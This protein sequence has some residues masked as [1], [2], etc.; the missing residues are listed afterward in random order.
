M[1]KGKTRGIN[2]STDDPTQFSLFP[3]K[4]ANT[5]VTPLES[6]P[7][8]LEG[9]DNYDE[10]LRLLNSPTNR[11]GLDFEFYE[12]TLRPT[13]IGLASEKE[14]CAIPW[15]PEAGRALEQWLRSPGNAF[16]AFAG[17]SADKPVLERA[18]GIKTDISRWRDPML[19]HYLH[20]QDLCSAPGK[21]ED[22]GSSLGFMN[23]WTAASL[24]T[25]AF[26]WKQCRGRTCAGP[27]PKHDVFAYCAMDAW[28]GLA[29]EKELSGK[30]SESL[31]NELHELAELCQMIT[32]QGVKVDLSFAKDFEKKT[33][34]LKDS[35]FPYA[36]ERKTK[37]YKEFNPQSS[38][39]TIEWFRNRGVIL[40][41]ADKKAVRKAL[42]AEAK[43]RGFENIAALERE[44]EPLPEVLDAL[45]RLWQY[46]NA[47][48]GTEAWFN[49]KHVDSE[50]FIHP[51][52][53]VTGTS[54]GRLASSKP[55]FQ[56]IPVRGWGSEVKRAIVPRR[57]DYRIVD[58]DL[59]QLELRMVLYL[60]GVD[61]R[62]I[63]TDAFT[64]LVQQSGGL[65]DK[66]AEL[67]RGSP[68]DIAKSV[69]HAGDYLEGFIT[70]DGNDL[71]KAYTK[72][73]I[74][75]GALRVYAKKYM[76]SLSK[77]WTFRGRVVAFTGANLAERLFGDRSFENRRKAL[78]IQE[79]VYF[80]RFP[81]IREWHRKVLERI[82]SSRRIVSPTGR[83]LR[84]YGSPEEDAKQA[85]AFLGQG[86]SADHVQGIMLQ[87]WRTYR[88]ELEA[89]DIVLLLQVHDSLVW[90]LP[91]DWSDERLLEFLSPMFEETW[92]LP[93]FRAPGKIKYGD[94]YGQMSPSSRQ[95][96]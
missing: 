50:G 67:F 81:M 80:K 54:T 82:E 65:F 77:D 71:A 55:N 20:N 58:V 36:L 47:G 57:P 87:F 51:R 34:E 6:L 52:F 91:R 42:E 1:P 17:I 4:I 9:R 37:I 66:A 73:A 76:P 79:D 96:T 11:L 13:I 26:N 33:Q 78:E 86:V 75:A 32:E 72:R 22:E 10:F 92:R 63:S 93:G 90:E 84:L 31:L 30:V 85:A 14:A 83:F 49:P 5:K 18:L 21:D 60:A 45:Y 61:P 89:K 2:I 41:G 59:S 44:Q 69:S 70:L 8:V 7:V 35:L 43:R 48:K 68:R 88:Q 64:W 62:A 29:V 46:K 25:K 74:E 53:I 28:A 19:R 95:P 39:Q 24:V 56:N 27:C 15:N 94:N 40:N 16:V 12:G 38:E 23:L 3:E